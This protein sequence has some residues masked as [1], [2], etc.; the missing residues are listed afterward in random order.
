MYTILE[1]FLFFLFF[2]LKKNLIFF[3]PLT[4]FWQLK[5][6]QTAWFSNFWFLIFD[7]F[8]EIFDKL[9]KNVVILGKGCIMDENITKW[10]KGLSKKVAQWIK[11]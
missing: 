7:F 10:M 9:K 8:G 2:K 11:C 6:F 4:H 1:I 3:F 5:T